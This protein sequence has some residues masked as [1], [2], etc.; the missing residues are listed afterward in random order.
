MFPHDGFENQVVFIKNTLEVSEMSFETFVQTKSN[1]CLYHARFARAKCDQQRQHRTTLDIYMLD[2]DE[3]RISNCR[4]HHPKQLFGTDN[5]VAVPK[6]PHSRVKFPRFRCIVMAISEES[7]GFLREPLPLLRQQ[8]TKVVETFY[9]T[10]FERYPQV[11][12]QFNTD[13]RAEQ[14][15]A[16][17]ECLLIAMQLE[18]GDL[19][20]QQ[21]LDAWMEAILNRAKAKAVYSGLA[22]MAVQGLEQHDD[23]TVL[24][25]ALKQHDVPQHGEGQVV[26]ICVEYANGEHGYGFPSPADHAQSM[27]PTSFKHHRKNS[28]QTPVGRSCALSRTRTS[29]NANIRGRAPKLLTPFDR[30]QP[31]TKTGRASKHAP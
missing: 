7:T 25:L 21:F 22:E 5:I 20:S 26:I 16:V 10:L 13:A 28:R 12:Q 30:A 8:G 1:W 9:N 29:A 4:Y 15:S 31:E 11:R 14:Y 6:H 2:L 18:L 17:D 19:A 3:H 27:L 24:S 23:R